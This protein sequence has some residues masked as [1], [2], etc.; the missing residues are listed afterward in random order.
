MVLFTARR[1]AVMF[2]V[3]LVVAVAVVVGVVAVVAVAI[4]R[5]TEVGAV[6]WRLQ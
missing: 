2:A 6:I 5:S 1:I 3:G 4:S